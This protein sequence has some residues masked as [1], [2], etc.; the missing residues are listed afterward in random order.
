MAMFDARNALIASS[1]NMGWQLAVMVLLPIALG[2]WLDKK[3]NTSPSFTLTAF[4]VAVAAGATVIV[5]TFREMN[6]ATDSKPR[7][8][9]V[10]NV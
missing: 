2:V 4:F 8:K 1:L 7:G 5:R 10:K 9:R 6:K 3:Y